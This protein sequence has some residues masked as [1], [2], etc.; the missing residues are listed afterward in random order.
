M[1]L[2][3]YGLRPAY[4]AQSYDSPATHA[5]VQSAIATGQSTSTTVSTGS[6][7]LNDNVP[8]NTGIPTYQFSLS[9]TVGGG[10]T[11]AFWE[12]GTRGD[13][14]VEVAKMH[15]TLT[16]ILT[17]SGFHAADGTIV[18]PSTGPEGRRTREAAR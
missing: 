2:V 17:V 3:W 9:S 7:S 13:P 10:G 4:Q 11:H 1:E 18:Q 6:S 5:G 14:A 12:W 16:G 15:S 8:A